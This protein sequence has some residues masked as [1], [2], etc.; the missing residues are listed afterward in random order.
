MI[1]TVRNRQKILPISASS[2]KKLLSALCTFYT[3]ET[4]RISIS[5][6]GKKESGLLHEKFFNDPTPTD[7]MSFP[8]DF[9]GEK[10]P[11][12]IP[13]ILGEI[14]VCPEVALEYGKKHGTDPYVET[15]LYVIHAFLHLIGYDD[16]SPTAKKVIR[17]EEKKCQLFTQGISLQ[18]RK[19]RLC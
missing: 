19:K 9:P 7:C 1:I 2:T 12:G 14:F 8:L 11:R 17:R 5:F 4:D 13:R 3:I 10:S 15:A 18:P 16:T 6:I